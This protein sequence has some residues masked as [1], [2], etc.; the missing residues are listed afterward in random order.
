[1]RTE[2]VTSIELSLF[3]A[4]GLMLVTINE[5]K[6]EINFILLIYAFF[7]KLFNL[8]IIMAIR[9]VH[10]CFVKVLITLLF[11]TYF[12]SIYLSIYLSIYISH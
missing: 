3:R 10:K 2:G 7:K 5:N 9:Q 12:V 11:W 6:I 1:M 8:E 4:T